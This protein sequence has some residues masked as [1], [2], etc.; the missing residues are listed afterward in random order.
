MRRGFSVAW[1]CSS[2]SPWLRWPLT[3]PDCWT[4]P[5]NIRTRHPQTHTCCPS[6]PWTGWH[7]PCRWP[8]PMEPCFAREVRVWNQP[9]S[10]KSPESCCLSKLTFSLP[11]YT[12]MSSL[13]SVHVLETSSTLL[14]F[15]FHWGKVWLNVWSNWL[16]HL[17]SHIQPLR[18]CAIIPFREFQCQKDSC[19]VIVWTESHYQAEAH[20]VHSKHFTPCL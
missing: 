19:Q 20:Q 1:R 4:R 11:Y 6:W 8:W 5:T 18:N 12:C 16:L 10:S 9:L 2:W 15:T 13:F 14:F 7:R 3:F 17:H